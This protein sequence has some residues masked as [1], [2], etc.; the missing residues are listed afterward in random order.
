MPLVTYLDGNFW[1][2]DSNLCQ[3]FILILSPEI[4]VEHY[5]RDRERRILFLWYFLCHYFKIHDK[6]LTKYK[7]TFS[8]FTSFNIFQTME[9]NG[10][11]ALFQRSENN[12]NLIYG[13]YIC[14]G[15]SKAYS[16]VKNSMPYG[17]LIYVNKAECRAHITKRMGTGLRTIVKN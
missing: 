10:A 12:R 15:D 5:I 3:S 17:P 2:S 14:D 13:T 11:S 9:S 6:T 4:F 1:A 8:K 16:S 7:N